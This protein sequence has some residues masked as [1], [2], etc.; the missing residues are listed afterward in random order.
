MKIVERLEIKFFYFLNVLLLGVYIFIVNIFCMKKIFELGIKLHKFCLGIPELKFFYDILDDGYKFTASSPLYMD[1][2][3]E[4]DF[5]MVGKIPI[6]YYNKIRNE[7]T[8]KNEWVEIK[9]EKHESRLEQHFNIHLDMDEDN[10][11]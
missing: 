5:L 8:K 6:S 4:N 10:D 1:E 7:F 3:G 9:E 11:Y 2:T